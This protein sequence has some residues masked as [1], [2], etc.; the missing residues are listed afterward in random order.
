MSWQ[1]ESI[2]GA[3]P[4]LV[5]ANPVSNLRIGES[6]SLSSMWALCWLCGPLVQ[7]ANTPLELTHALVQG[8]IRL[9]SRKGHTFVAVFPEGESPSDIQAAV[10]ELREGYPNLIART[11]FRDD[12]DKGLIEIAPG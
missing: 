10:L 3:K 12:W 7:G 1:A 6:I 11:W 2:A 9:Y 8:L 4:R 5:P